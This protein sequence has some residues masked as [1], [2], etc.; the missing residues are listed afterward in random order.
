MRVERDYIILWAERFKQGEWWRKGWG[1]YEHRKDMKTPLS[2][3][4]VIQLNNIRFEG[5]YARKEDTGLKSNGLLKPKS[6]CQLWVISIK[7]AGYRDHG[8]QKQYR[9]LPFLLVT[10]TGMR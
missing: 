1:R 4:L 5:R 3:Y 6:S 8:A 10:H 9:L 7:A 2:N